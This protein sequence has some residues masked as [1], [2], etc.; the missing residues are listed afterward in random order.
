MNENNI[1]NSVVLLCAQIDGEKKL[2]R[3]TTFHVD[4][5]SLISNK[6]S[7]EQSEIRRDHREEGK[8]YNEKTVTIGS[9]FD[10]NYVWEMQVPDV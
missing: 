3:W 8:P 1:R 5:I 2:E 7:C 10:L 6:S 9:D 4:F